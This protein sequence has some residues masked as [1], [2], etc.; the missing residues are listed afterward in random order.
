VKWSYFNQP[1]SHAAQMVNF[2][3]EGVA[4]ET[5][6]SPVDGSSV[7]MRLE[8]DASQCRP[9]CSEPVECPWPRSMVLGHVKWSRPQ[10]QRPSRW[11]VG[12]QVYFR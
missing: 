12:I 8:G 5:D 4:L 10:G 7:V 9:D 2:S 1:Q 6:E 3:Q 11:A